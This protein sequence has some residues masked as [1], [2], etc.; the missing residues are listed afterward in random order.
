M[1]RREIIDEKFLGALVATA[2]IGRTVLQPPLDVSSTQE[3]TEGG[4][5]R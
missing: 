2:C 5:V 4:A 3:R 1:E